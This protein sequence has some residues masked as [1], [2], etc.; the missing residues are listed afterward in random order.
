MICA[1]S[2]RTPYILLKALY[3]DFTTF[4]GF[5]KLDFHFVDTNTSIVE[6]DILN[7]GEYIADLK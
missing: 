7:A 1:C 4:D 2:V 3:H 5:I 6:N